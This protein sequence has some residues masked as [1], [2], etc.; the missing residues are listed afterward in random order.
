MAWQ[1][2]EL[3]NSTLAIVACKRDNLIF[4]QPGFAYRD[5]QDGGKGMKLPALSRASAPQRLSV[6]H[7]PIASA[8]HEWRCQAQVEQ[9][10]IHLRM[11][12]PLF[13]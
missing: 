6:M 5:C 11:S 2:G 1:H 8:N 7:A 4:E 12:L 3:Q 13:D 9:Q 10:A